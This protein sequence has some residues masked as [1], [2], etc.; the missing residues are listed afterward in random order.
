MLLA[1]LGVPVSERIHATRAVRSALHGC[2]MLEQQGGFGLDV[3]VDAS[4]AWLVA[5][6]VRGVRAD[7]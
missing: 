1:G 5:A 4:F 6:I 3:D 7:A 2:A